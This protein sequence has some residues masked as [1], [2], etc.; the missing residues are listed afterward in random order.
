MVFL[1]SHCTTDML[2]YSKVLMIPETSRA[3]Y[4]QQTP[5]RSRAW[6]RLKARPRPFFDAFGPSFAVSKHTKVCQ[7]RNDHNEVNI[8]LGINDQAAA[9]EVH[10]PIPADSQRRDGHL[11]SFV[12]PNPSM[13]A[14]H[15]KLPLIKEN[16]VAL[17][18]LLPPRI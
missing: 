13:S 14:D 2:A 7:S 8:R 17:D 4:E 3:S 9:F 16:R 15:C 11:R 6:P 1:V 18:W 12:W 10:P 5:S